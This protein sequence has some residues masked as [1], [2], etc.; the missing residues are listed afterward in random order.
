MESAVTVLPE[1]NSPTSATVSALPMSKE[2][3]FTAWTTLPPPPRKSTDRSSTL[4][5]VVFRRGWLGA[6]F[7]VGHRSSLGALRF[8]SRIGA[9]AVLDL[10]RGVIQAK[11]RMQPLLDGLHHA[12][13]FETFI[14]AGMQRHHLPL[15]GDRPH[16]HMVHADHP[17]DVGDEVR[18]DMARVELD[19]A[20]L[21]A[22]CGPRPPRTFQP[23]LSTMTATRI[24]SRG[25][26]GVQPVR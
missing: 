16:M 26:I 9:H 25:S 22:G 7:R 23:L 4:T 3:F 19:A 11:A 20:P 18:L 17:R 24:E 1:P 12:V 14:D 8:G 10:D 15:L 5:S 21:R 2:T 13:P 6:W